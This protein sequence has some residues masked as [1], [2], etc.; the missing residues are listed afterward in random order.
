MLK[1]D[2]LK[3]QLTKIH[4]VPYMANC[5]RLMNLKYLIDGY[6]PLSGNGYQY[7][8]G[9]FHTKGSYPTIYLAEEI[10]TT[11]DETLNFKQRKFPPFIIWSVEVRFSRLLDLRDEKNLYLLDTT[12][13]EMTGSWQR[14]NDNGQM[15]PTQLLAQ[16]VYD[17]GLFEGI[18]YL[19]SKSDE[20]Q[21]NI[22]IFKERLE[23]T[24]YAK[25]F[26]P[27]GVIQEELVIIGESK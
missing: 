15:A 5:F 6:T 14:S 16:I 23:P 18:L 13:Q 22:V 7:S 9:R 27:D 19:S 11:M 12:I 8:S 20:E 3:I 24:S 21:G 25:A 26:D 10:E 1:M 2:Q 17:S 4:P